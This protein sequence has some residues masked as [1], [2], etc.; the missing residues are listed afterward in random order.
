MFLISAIDFNKLK[1]NDI[2]N[3]ISKGERLIYECNNCKHRI[4]EN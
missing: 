1:G 3:S 4:R 2:Q